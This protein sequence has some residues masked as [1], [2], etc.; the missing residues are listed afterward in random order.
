MLR[1]ISAWLVVILAI[2]GI[3]AG[4]AYYKYAELQ[5]AAAAA[6]ATPEPA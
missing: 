1:Q 2:A 3:S 4:F 6:A 5:A